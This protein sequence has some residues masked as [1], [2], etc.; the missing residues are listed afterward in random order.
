MDF[1]MDLDG[2]WEGGSSW[3][4][5]LGLWRDKTKSL[6]EKWE[7]A[8]KFREKFCMLNLGENLVR[9]KKLNLKNP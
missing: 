1:G 3:V 7:K 4:E 6:C 2:S 9:K 5:K 8:G